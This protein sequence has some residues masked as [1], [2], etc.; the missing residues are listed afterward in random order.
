MAWKIEDVVIKG[1]KLFV[2]ASKEFPLERLAFLL[3][4]D[5]LPDAESVPKKPKKL[6]AKKGKLSDEEK[7]EKA[8]EYQRNWVRKKREKQE[9]GRTPVQEKADKL[10]K[11][12]DKALERQAEIIAVK[13]EQR[14]IYN[15]RLTKSKERP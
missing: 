3:D 9:A 15:E 5:V 11:R 4:A 6:K 10:I 1:E 7:R 14:R 13:E 12:A 8:R 2:T